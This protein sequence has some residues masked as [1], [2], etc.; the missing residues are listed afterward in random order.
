[1]SDGRVDFGFG[2]GGYEPEHRA[3]GIPFPDRCRAL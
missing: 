2:A 1:M 3:Y